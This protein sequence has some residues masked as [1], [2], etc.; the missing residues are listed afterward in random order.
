MHDPV[1]DGIETVGTQHPH[2]CQPVE[3]PLGRFFM[4]GHCPFFFMHLIVHG[5]PHGCLV[6]NA[7]D[8][9]LHQSAP[10]RRLFYRGCDNLEFERRA[11]AVDHQNFHRAH[12]SRRLRR[13]G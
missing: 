7:F 1:T 12:L 6:P 8:H 11:P 13:E 10:L 2:R 4:V 3:H 9:T 5:A